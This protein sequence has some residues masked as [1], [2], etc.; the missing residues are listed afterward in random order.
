ML[1]PIGCPARRRRCVEGT[2][3][4]VWEREDEEKLW[5]VGG[6]KWECRRRPKT[7]A[8]AESVVCAHVGVTGCHN[9]YMAARLRCARLLRGRNSR[10]GSRVAGNSANPVPQPVYGTDPFTPFNRYLPDA[11]G[12]RNIIE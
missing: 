4:F 11:R 12:P 1:V 7:K 3:G 9:P 6:G 5:E 10:S 8:E 2:G